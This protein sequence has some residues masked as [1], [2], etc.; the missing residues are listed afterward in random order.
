M[1]FKIGE[2][3]LFFGEGNFSFSLSVCKKLVDQLKSDLG[4][5]DP[6]PEISQDG[7]RNSPILDRSACAVDDQVFL[8]L[9]HVTCTCYETSP[10]SE[11]A[12]ENVQDLFSLGAVVKFG[13]DAT[14][15]EPLFSGEHFDKVGKILVFYRKAPN[16]I[17]YAFYYF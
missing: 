9:G 6:A 7:S 1:D 10:V 16:F 5:S 4:T 12:E 11:T 13:V 2:K 3:L 15:L 17:P 8:G 14:K